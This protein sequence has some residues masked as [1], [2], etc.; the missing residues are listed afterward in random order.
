MDID[1]TEEEQKALTWKIDLRLIPYLSVLYFFSFLDRVNVGNV[2]TPLKSDLA[3]TES[4]FALIV[5]IF[6]VGYILFELP[7]NLLM[8]KATPS[9]WIARIMFLWG[10]ICVCMAFAQSFTSLV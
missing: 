3:L 9:R 7:S 5:G 4:E 2:H 1:L 8:K 10:A 6:F